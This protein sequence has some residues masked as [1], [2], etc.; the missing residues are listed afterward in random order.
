MPKKKSENILLIIM[1]TFLT[2]SVGTFLHDP[3]LHGAIALI[4]GWD[5]SSYES[6][7]TTGSTSVQLNSASALKAD[8]AQLWVFY[9]FP[10]L[11]L[12]TAAWLVNIFY[13]DRLTR[14]IGVLVMA[15]NLGSLEPANAGSDADRA[16]QVLVY[17]GWS[18]FTASAAHWIILFTA[19]LMLALFL[20][21]VI[22]DSNK[23]AKARQKG[24]G[25]RRQ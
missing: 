25:V 22:E 3:L 16:A 11:F 9:M 18:E 8:T 24:L 20:F 12:F 1:V 7:L 23:D 13:P 19:V 14:I 21:V 2:L 15:L 10:S 17:G 5:I 6:Y 4:N